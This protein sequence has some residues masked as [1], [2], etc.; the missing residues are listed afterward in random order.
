MA[1]KTKKSPTPSTAKK[2]GAELPMDSPKGTRSSVPPAVPRLARHRSARGMPAAGQHVPPE[3][4]D[5]AKARLELVLSRLGQAKDQ[6][7]GQAPIEPAHAE[8]LFGLVWAS[9]EDLD[10]MGRTEREI[11]P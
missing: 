9:I 7:N 10:E 11:E 1:Q 3:P 5:R 6:G 2:T 8:A 4:V